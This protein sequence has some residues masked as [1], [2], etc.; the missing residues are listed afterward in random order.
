M[1]PN[2]ERKP[3][4]LCWRA[5][6]GAGARVTQEADLRG[7]T[8][9]LACVAW[10]LASG[11]PLPPPASAESAEP[12]ALEI[13]MDFADPDSVGNF[14]E[15]AGYARVEAS[16]EDLA[17][18]RSR[19]LRY[20]SRWQLDAS[21]AGTAGLFR[22]PGTRGALTAC[23]APETMNEPK[24]IAWCRWFGFD[25]KGFNGTKIVCVAE[26]ER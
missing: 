16:A 22:V 21:R 15:R 1:N 6:R 7:A 9:L 4:C 12:V 10:V 11:W 14:Y 23:Y 2:S 5:I 24:G 13:V 18:A 20:A 3:K 25:Y 8:M 17:K 19:C 26:A